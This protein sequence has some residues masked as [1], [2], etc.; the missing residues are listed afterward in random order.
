M[1]SGGQGD[2]NGQWLQKISPDQ[3]IANQAGS[4]SVH[5]HFYK[6][7]AGLF[8]KSMAGLCLGFNPD[9]F[10]LEYVLNENVAHW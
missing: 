6:S 3:S 8:Y 4:R 10:I 5:L 9:Y 7:M 2:L 1:G